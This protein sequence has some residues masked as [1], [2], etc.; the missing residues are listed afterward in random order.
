MESNDEE[1]LVSISA[2]FVLCQTSR[3]HLKRGK[4]S[5]GI[6]NN[7]AESKEMRAI[8]VIHLKKVNKSEF[9]VQ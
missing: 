6:T 4:E 8:N 1:G 7:E 2:T 9:F 3:L 5:F